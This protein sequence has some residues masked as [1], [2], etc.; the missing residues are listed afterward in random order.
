MLSAVPD[1]RIDPKGEAQSRIGMDL[2]RRGF[3]RHGF[4]AG[5][6]FSDPNRSRIGVRERRWE[7]S[8]GL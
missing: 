4:P 7:L 3:L 2:G 8:V 5:F 1:K 6:P